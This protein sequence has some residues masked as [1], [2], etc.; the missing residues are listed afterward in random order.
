MTDPLLHT[1]ALVMTVVSAACP[2]SATPTAERDTRAADAATSIAQPPTS[3]AMTPVA[4][5]DR[6]YSA[7]SSG[8]EGSA[9]RVVSDRAQWESDW[10]QLHGGLAAG[11]APQVDFGRDVVVPVAM[12]VHNSGG[13]AVRIDGTSP[14]GNDL[15]VH[16]TLV[17]PGASCMTTQE[18]TQPAEA[19]RV[20][21]PA[22]RVRVVTRT[23]TT[24]C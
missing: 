21:K 11:S 6:L 5:G 16:V 22:G 17:A 15:T 13:H 8:F 4:A 12:G 19:V 18:I 10:R 24:A 3:S 20:R 2:G 23:E 7:S 9:Q 1:R 14:S